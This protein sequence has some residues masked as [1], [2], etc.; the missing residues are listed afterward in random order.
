[1]GRWAGMG[2]DW[3]KM[4]DAVK[5]MNRM[6]T[7]ELFDCFLTKE[8]VEKF[9]KQFPPGQLSL[10]TD[11]CFFIFQITSLL[12]I[13]NSLGEMRNKRILEFPL[14]YI[15]IYLDNDLNKK[16]ISLFS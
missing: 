16:K 8:F 11:K 1:M 14:K 12:D 15:W 2:I 5:K 9:G 6:K 7:I 10:I 4:F 13:L 3:S